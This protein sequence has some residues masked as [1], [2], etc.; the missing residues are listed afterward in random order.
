MERITGH[1]F[2]LGLGDHTMFNPHNF[3]IQLWA[4]W[5]GFGPRA[6][7]WWSL[8]LFCE[9][10]SSQHLLSRHVGN[11]MCL[12]SVF[13]C[14]QV[15]GLGEYLNDPVKQH[16]LIRVLPSRLRRQL[17][18]KRWLSHFLSN[19][20]SGCLLKFNVS[21]IFQEV[22]VLLL[23]EPAEVG[24]H[25]TAAVWSCGKIQG[26]RPGTVATP[27][28]TITSNHLVFTGFQTC[29]VS[30]CKYIYCWV[31]PPRPS[32]YTHSKC[33]LKSQIM[34]KI[35]KWLIWPAASSSMAP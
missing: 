34:W 8:S 25:G 10:I 15:E 2:S 23:W 35:F 4:A 24:L 29:A 1:Y 9:V 12:S 27:T 19:Y 33:C 22:S 3:L 28:K 6:T 5:A 21:F 14:Q 7:S 26:E 20:V 31:P 13:V 16:F 18:Y 32:P 11:V 30:I 17:L